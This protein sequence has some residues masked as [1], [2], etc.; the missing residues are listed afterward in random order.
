MS[1]A[2]HRLLL[3]PILD[4]ETRDVDDLLDDDDLEMASSWA[5]NAY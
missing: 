2:V 1:Q 3:V 4:D 5:S